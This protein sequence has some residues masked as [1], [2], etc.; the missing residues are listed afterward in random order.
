MIITL[1]MAYDVITQATSS[2][3]APNEPAIWV[4][5]TFTMVVS[6][7]SIMAAVM[8]VI[9]IMYFFIIISMEQ[10]LPSKAPHV[11]CFYIFLNPISQ[12][13]RVLSV[14]LLQNCQRHCREVIKKF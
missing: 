7:N 12:F 1:A 5:A 9:T 4:K 8:V 3:V 6:S 14:L 2:I 13:S 10:I 11:E